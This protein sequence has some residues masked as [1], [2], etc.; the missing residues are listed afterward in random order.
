VYVPELAPD[1][2]Y[3][4]WDGTSLEVTADEES[5]LADT[6]NF[7]LPEGMSWLTRADVSGGEGGCISR[8]S[9][10]T[11]TEDEVKKMNLA[12]FIIYGPD[13]TFEN[14][15]YGP[16]HESPLFA[17]GLEVGIINLSEILPVDATV[18]YGFFVDNS[19]PFMVVLT[20][21]MNWAYFG[22]S[23]HADKFAPPGTYGLDYT[24]TLTL[25]Q[26][27][28]ANVKQLEG[29]YLPN[30]PD[31]SVNEYSSYSR[32]TVTDKN[33]LTKTVTVRNG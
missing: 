7:T 21:P 5:D 24:G 16:A 29:K 12:S 3:A 25:A 23:E 4:Y 20:Q 18:G 32:I 13:D 28:Y 9:R 14:L 31:I 26:I 10:Y 2:S 19:I 22:V 27:I 15:V 8:M 11:F 6:I 1:G 17:D 33:N 30:W